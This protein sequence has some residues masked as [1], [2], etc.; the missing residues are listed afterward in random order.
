MTIK[1]VDVFQVSADIDRFLGDLA[2]LEVVC[3]DVLQVIKKHLN[4]GRTTHGWQGGEMFPRQPFGDQPV[5]LRPALGRS[6]LAKIKSR[7]SM[8]TTAKPRA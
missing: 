1:E 8:V 4:H 7:S 6:V 5:I 3:V 2:I